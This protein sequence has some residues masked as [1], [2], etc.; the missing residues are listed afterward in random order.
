MIDYLYSQVSRT[1]RGVLFDTNIFLAYLVGCWDIRQVNRFPRISDYDEDDIRLLQSLI[2]TIGEITITPGV[3]TEVCNLSD[4]LN[5]QYDYGFFQI[6]REL[7]ERAIDRR[8]ESSLV[9]NNPSFLRLGFADAGII[10]CSTS[11]SL[12]VTDDLDCYR[13]GLRQNG[14]I[15]NINHV[16]S[17]TWL[18]G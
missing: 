6:V 11:G 13:E 8:K 17:S 1:T 10:E 12:V 2:L 7:S 3:L 18:S 14:L 5:R 15:I 4:K 9:C 16:R